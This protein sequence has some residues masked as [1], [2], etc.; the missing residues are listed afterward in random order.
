MAWRGGPE[1]SRALHDA[2]PILRQVNEVRVITI[3][4]R[5]G[6]EAYQSHDADICEHM[7]RYQLPLIC[8]KRVSGPLSVGDM[9]LN[10][11]ADSGADLLIM[12]ATSQSRRGYQTLG[13]TGQHLLKC[14]T[15]PVIMSH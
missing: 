4:G 9:L 2:M 13:E 1:S 10:R 12:G 7:S 14:M 15:V 6:D 11:C 5:E 8:E 3:Q